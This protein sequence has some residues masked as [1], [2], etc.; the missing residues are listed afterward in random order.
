MR[1][2]PATGGRTSPHQPAAGA[3]A[4]ESQAG[5]AAAGEDAGGYAPLRF[6]RA[7]TQYLQRWLHPEVEDTEAGW[8]EWMQAGRK[9]ES[10]PRALSL[11]PTRRQLLELAPAAALLASCEAIADATLVAASPEEPPPARRES[12]ASPAPRTRA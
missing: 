2:H 12:V 1:P 6:T 3:D 5:P 10:L 11:Q 4:P 8:S 9:M 7:Q